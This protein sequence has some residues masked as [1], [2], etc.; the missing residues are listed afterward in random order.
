MPSAEPNTVVPERM[1]DLETARAAHG[2]RIDQLARKLMVGDPLADA[3]IAELDR[4]GKEGRRLLNAGLTDGLESLGPHPPAAIAALLRQVEAVPSWVDP[5]MLSRGERATISVPPLWFQ[6]CGMSSALVHTYS[7]P[8]IARLLVQTGKLT[9]MAPRRLVETG[10]WVRQATAPGGLLRGA[11]GYIA[12]VQVRLL[13]ARMRMAALQHGWDSA[14]WG[15]PISQVD[16]A[17]TWLDFTLTPFHALATA[18]IELTGA[19]DRDL[20]AYWSYVAHLLGLEE[21]FYAEAVDARSARVLLDLLDSTTAPPDDNSRALTTAMIGA[22]VD[23][24]AGGPRPL[25]PR[26]ALEDLIHGLL[27]RSFGDA[28][29]DSLGIPVSSATPF[30]PLLALVNSQ[31]RRWQTLTADSAEQARRENAAGP[32]PDAVAALVP[33]GPA[34][35]RHLHGDTADPAA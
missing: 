3:V 13:H 28:L 19:E 33:G 2:G 34:Y 1:V 8:A 26:P 25:M 7:S 29:A 12:T 11:P 10:M 18:G 17:R 5:A 21:S 6:L 32:S 24:L 4:L 31:S 27:R 15:T 23:A 22:Q 9:T 30:L 14:E 20:Y 35:H 16:V